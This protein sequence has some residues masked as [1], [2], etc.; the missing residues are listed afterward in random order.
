[1]LVPT[2]NTLAK[3]LFFHKTPQNAEPRHALGLEGA[4][5]ARFQ[6]VREPL[7]LAVVLWLLAQDRV[8]RL[9]RPTPSITSISGRRSALRGLCQLGRTAGAGA[10]GVC[11]QGRGGRRATLQRLHQGHTYR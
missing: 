6:F 10:R 4:I 8:P 9:E 7:S 3:T 1:M 5:A 11:E 2:A